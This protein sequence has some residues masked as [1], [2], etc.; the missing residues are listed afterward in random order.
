MDSYLSPAAKKM[1]EDITTFMVKVNPT[2]YEFHE[3]SAFPH[4][5]IPEIA[6]LGVVGADY[7][8]E[9]GGKDFTIF[10]M[11]SLMYEF[12]RRD[13][14]VATFFL[15]H[16]SLGNYT[17]LKLAQPALRDKIFAETLNVSKVL[18][19]A[20]TE[21]ETGSDASSIQS[22][23][24]KVD[25]G[26]LLNG[27]KRWIGNATFSDFILVWA[28]NL[29]ENGAIQCFLLRKGSKGLKTSKIEHK[30]ALRAV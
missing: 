2:L 11:G 6:Q 26:Y 10:E 23:A 5:L 29:A 16:H 27:C 12:A 7:S 20:L 24:K 21:P 4:H 1:K 19:W 15:L 17:L 25:G 18:A 28:R 9:F 22:T 3:K 8:K 14:S 13:A 30:V